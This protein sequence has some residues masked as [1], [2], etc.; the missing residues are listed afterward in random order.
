MANPKGNEASLR[1]SRFKAAWQSGS[2][3]TIRV[4]VVLAE[5]V[6]EYAH[7]LDN[8]IEPRDTMNKV[9]SDV[10]VATS[11]F[12]DTRDSSDEVQQLKAEVERLQDELSNLQAEREELA[13][14]KKEVKEA[15]AEVHREGNAIN[16][17]R[18]RWQTELSSAKSELKD[19]Q[20][21]I[22][23]QGNKIRELERGYSLKPNPAETRLR[24]EIGE[25]REQLSDLQQ[26]LAAPRGLPEAADLLN[27]LKSKRKKATASFADIKA[28]LGILEEL[29]P[30]GGD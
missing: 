16:V 4:P 11:Q 1:D 13:Q 20:A 18:S 19:A 21:I 7:L 3:R 25:L 26:Q 2:T 17:E 22:L 9:N 30:D 5:T 15:A 8:G 27:Q 12:I 6:L 10:E 29:T 28:I 14:L 23:N 24:L